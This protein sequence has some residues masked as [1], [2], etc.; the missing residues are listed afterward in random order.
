MMGFYVGLDLGQASDYTAIGVIQ[1]VIPDQNTMEIINHAPR[2]PAQYH[3]RHLERPKLGTPYPAI[4]ERVKE[5]MGTSP[6]AGQAVLVIDFTGVGRPVGDM[7]KRAGLSFVPVS[8]HGGDKVSHDADGYK[9]PKR[10]LVGSL[11]VLFQ[12]KRLLV[13]ED[14]PEAAALVRELLAFRAKINVATGHDSYEAWREGDHDDL[15]LATALA[16][17]YAESRGTGPG[18]R[19]RRAA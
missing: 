13:A 9:V 12:S 15:V 11:Q 1:Q 17:W 7:L 5:L 6:L 10:D 4:A 18:M 8:I 16:V 2:K 14:L 19:T 3:L